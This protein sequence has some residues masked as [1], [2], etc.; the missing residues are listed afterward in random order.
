MLK[1]SEVWRAIDRL[2]VKH[3]FSAS[4]LA[5]RSGLDPTTFNKSKRVTK[6]GKQRW[7]STESVAKILEATGASMA[8]FV[9]LIDSEPARGPNQRLLLAG[10]DQAGQE[11]LFDERGRPS[12]KSWDEMLFPRIDDGDAYAL[13]I[14]DDSFS[15]VYG[16]GDV[17][18]VSPGTEIRRGDRVVVRTNDGKLTIGLLMRRGVRRLEVASVAGGNSVKS[19]A[20]AKVAWLARIVWSSH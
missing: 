10:L 11:G 9:D 13:E 4:G 5:R 7:P 18:V 12:G 19:L 15:P 3:G 8:E 1:H 2:A 6:E 20:V 16:E 14:G 17:I